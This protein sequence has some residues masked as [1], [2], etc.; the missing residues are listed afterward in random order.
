MWQNLGWNE[1]CSYDIN[2]T[3]VNYYHQTWSLTKLTFQQSP[4]AFRYFNENVT[5]CRRC[6]I[7][8][9][10]VMFCS[11]RYKNKMK[12]IFAHGRAFC[13][14]V[15]QSSCKH[16]Q[17]VVKLQST[18]WLQGFFGKLVILGALCNQ[19]WWIKRVFFYFTYGEISFDS[20][21]RW[22]DMIE[23]LIYW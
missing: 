7:L 4:N 16:L 3:Q 9:F 5:W 10:Q 12:L 23:K 11:L 20:F 2:E 6:S 1:N 17:Y 14:H 8:Q 15:T 21:S 22:I 19:L 18:Y 13:S